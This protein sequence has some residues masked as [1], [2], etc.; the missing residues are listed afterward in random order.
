MQYHGREVDRLEASLGIRPRYGAGICL[1]RESVRIGDHMKRPVAF[2][3]VGLCT[4]AVADDTVK[5]VP[6][7]GGLTAIQIDHADKSWG[8]DGGFIC[9]F[10]FD[11]AGKR[12]HIEVNTPKDTGCPQVIWIGDRP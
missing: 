2:L 4:A 11:I 9:F 7:S 3:L 10:Y 6:K 8:N 1:W 12:Y 5:P